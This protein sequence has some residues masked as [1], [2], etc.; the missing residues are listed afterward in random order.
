FSFDNQNGTTYIYLDDVYYEDLS[1]CIFPMNLAA[2]AIT[3]TGATFSWDA[4]LASGVTGY[5]WE[6]R[7]SGAPGTAGAVATGT[8]TAPTT[9]AT[10]NALAGA[11]TY[12]VYVRSVCGT[13]NGV[14]TTFPVQFN[15]LCPI[16]SA[17][18]F[19]GFETT[20][21]GA[22]GNQNAPLCWTN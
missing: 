3:I 21:N 6:V 11:T 2:N 17:N 8:T 22:S 10:T 9:T 19:E 15:T 5:E 16:F 18:F 7:T 4:S 20:E 1:P 13:N 12:Y 14:W